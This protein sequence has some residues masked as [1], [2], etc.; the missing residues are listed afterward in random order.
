MSKPVGR[1]VAEIYMKRR[2][3]AAAR[4][5][6]WQEEPAERKDTVVG[7]KRGRSKECDLG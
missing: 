4:Q 6:L 2:I 1:K 3:A 7:E 5:P